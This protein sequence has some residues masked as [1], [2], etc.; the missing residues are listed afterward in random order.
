[1]PAPHRVTLRRSLLGG[2]AS[3]AIAASGAP[4][5]ESDPFLLFEDGQ[6]TVRATLQFGANAVSEAN[7]FWNLSEGAAPSSGF[8]PDA[9]WLELYVEPGLNFSTALG[10]DREFYGRL[11]AVAS[12]TAGIDAFDTGDTGRVTLEEAY[13]GLRLPLGAASLDVS[14]GPRELRLATG[15]LISDGGS[16][17]FERGA[18]KFGPRRAWEEA[19][20]AELSI[21]ATT[22]TLFFIDP[23][24]RAETDGSNELAGLDLRYDGEGGSF[25]GATY[26]DVVTSSSP[27]P[28]AAPGGVGPPSVLAGAREDT[29]TLHLYGQ[30]A[31]LGGGW[32]FGVDLALQRNDRIDLEAAA[33]RVQVSYAFADARF[34]PVLTYSYQAFSGD[35]PDT[36]ELE[37]FDPLFYDGSPSA[38][39][40]GSKSAMLFINSNVRAHNLALR[41]RPSE[42]DTLTIRYAH[43]RADELR[44]PIQFGQATRV[45]LVGGTANVFA[46][47]TDPHLSDDLFVEF[48][49]VLNRNTFLTAGLSVSRPGEGIRN[50]FN[51]DPYWTGGFVNVVFNF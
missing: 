17:G 48:S 39:A 10:G 27:Y 3:A 51:D 26:I 37:R 47:V 11:S 45:D 40:T 16:D 33:G 22:G 46:G 43:V 50:V 2:L 7:L 29:E 36:P 31:P 25:F 23:N 34:S 19:G 32:T 6:T 13:L 24:E 12:Y 8:D 21:G 5:Q 18:L 9:T 44:S 14:V 30:T 49:R 41:L 28:Q 42:R 35:D 38:W 20:I 1:M 4:A 15:M